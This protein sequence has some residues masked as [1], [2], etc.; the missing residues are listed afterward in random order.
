MKRFL[1]EQETDSKPPEPRGERTP[2]EAAQYTLAEESGETMSDETMP[3]ELDAAEDNEERVVWDGSEAELVADDGAA[4]YEEQNTGIK[5][6]YSLKSEEIFKAMMK[7]QYTKTRIFFSVTAVLLSF[8]LIGSSIRASVV[9]NGGFGLLVAVCAALILLT[10][11][12]P[13]VNTSRLAKKTAADSKVKMKIYPDHIEMGRDEA[14]WE[15]PL[16]G[17]RE[18]TVFQNL[19]LLYIDAKNMVILPLRCVEPAVLP[20][21]QAMIFA[22][23]QPKK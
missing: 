7:N 3:E 20:E 9:G 14:I 18:R 12:I 10:V 4:E 8:V 17:T 11:G 2:E 16:D 6:K 13:F 15:I 1:D 22:G 23:T 19:I 21:V 5:L